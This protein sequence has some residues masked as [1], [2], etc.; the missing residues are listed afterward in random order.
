MKKWTNRKL[1]DFKSGDVAIN[2]YNK[3]IELNPNYAEAYFERGNLK[4][5][6]ENYEE[7]LEDIERASEINPD[8]NQRP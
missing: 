4:Y 5:K 7:V 3:A 8:F 1:G 6:L 2:Y